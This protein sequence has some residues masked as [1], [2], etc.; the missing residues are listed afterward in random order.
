MTETLQKLKKLFLSKIGEGREGA[1]EGE[2]TR[3]PVHTDI[4]QTSF[5]LQSWMKERDVSSGK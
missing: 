3:E 4:P 2:V 5:F 1:I